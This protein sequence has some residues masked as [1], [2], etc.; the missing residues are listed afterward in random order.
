MEMPQESAAA[1]VSG[2]RH[3]LSPNRILA[4]SFRLGRDKWKEK[5]HAVQAKLEQVRQLAAERGASREHWRKQCT[6]AVARAE[7]A[8]SLAAQQQTELEQVRVRLAELEAAAQ[9]KR[10]DPRLPPR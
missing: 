2:M 4:R 6:A 9:K 1:F 7:A 8:E 3:Y 10:A 5:H